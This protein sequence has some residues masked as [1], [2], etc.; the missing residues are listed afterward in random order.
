[1]VKD[2]EQN[3]DNGNPT[4]ESVIFD[5]VLAYCVANLSSSDIALEN[6]LTNSFN[7]AAVKKA[8]DEIW[9]NCDANIIGPKSKSKSK[10]S[11]QASD[12]IDALRKLQT[13]AKVPKIAV[14]AQDIGMLPRNDPEKV[15]YTSMCNRVDELEAAMCR[16]NSILGQLSAGNVSVTSSEAACNVTV[17][18][19]ESQQDKDDDNA[20]HVLNPNSQ[21]AR[22]LLQTNQTKPLQNPT[23][24][25]YAQKAATRVVGTGNKT[26]LKVSPKPHKI[27]IGGLDV[28]TKPSDVIDFVL[29]SIGIRVPCTQLRTRNENYTSFTISVDKN[30]LDRVFD[31]HCWPADAVIDFYKPPRSPRRHEFR[32]GGNMGPRASDRDSGRRYFRDDSDEY[33]ARQYV[34]QDYTERDFVGYGT[35]RD[36]R[37]SR[38]DNGEEE[39]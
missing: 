29:T 26:G 2:T 14:L 7:A 32:R 25:S 24:S 34:Q 33:Y 6:A 18:P 12:I 30:H 11:E 20:Q 23:K 13:E 15:D 22:P 9:T 19:D 10:K 35:N 39:K 5:A 31:P 17:I 16:V 36:I 38:Y 27:Y 21:Q 37:Y 3:Q 8:R 1:M 28:N 4:E